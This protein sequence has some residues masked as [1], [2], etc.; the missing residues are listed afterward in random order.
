MGTP[1]SSGLRSIRVAVRKTCTMVNV[2]PLCSVRSSTM[3]SRCSKANQLTPCDS[4]WK[5]YGNVSWNT[6]RL[7]SLY[8]SCL[9][10]T[11]VMP[12]STPYASVTLSCA[13]LTSRKPQCTTSGF[14]TVRIAMRSCLTWA[15]R[16]M[17]FIAIIRAARTL[18]STSNASS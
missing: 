17:T 1:Q 8:S 14:R 12:R 3:G 15:L 10:R 13:V 9:T 7:A 11:L 16:V 4:T 6:V 2:W 5:T 18:D